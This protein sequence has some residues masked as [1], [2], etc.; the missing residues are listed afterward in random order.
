M[1]EVILL[2]KEELKNI[3][4]ESIQEAIKQRALENNYLTR[5]DLARRL[6]VS[7]VTID[8]WSRSGLLKKHIVKGRVYFLESEVRASVLGDNKK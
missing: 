6:G 8:N 3:I 4:G 7:T 2:T 1:Q 5:K